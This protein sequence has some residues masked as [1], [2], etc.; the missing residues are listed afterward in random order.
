MMLSECRKATPRATSL[1][2]LSTARR[3]YW[4]PLGAFSSTK[5]PDLIALSSVPASHSS[6]WR[7]MWLQNHTLCWIGGVVGGCG[8]VGYSPNEVPCDGLVSCVDCGVGAAHKRCRQMHAWQH[9]PHAA[10]DR[11]GIMPRV[12]CQHQQAATSRST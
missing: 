9:V 12:G 7:V 4:E 5:A 6:C 8:G 11:P 1:A 3:W 10:S 2:V